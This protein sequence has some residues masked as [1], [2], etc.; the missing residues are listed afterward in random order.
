MQV[1]GFSLDAQRDKLV[2][3]AEY[4]DF[5]IVR[6]YCDAGKS[7]KS[8]TGR[9]QFM[10]MM[11]DVET[12]RD[13]EVSFVLVFKL[14][15]FGR[16]AADV[17]NSL[18]TL[19]D[20]GV[21]LICVE[22]G[23]DSSKDS[24]KLTITVLSAVA[25]IE[26]EN[27]LIQT[28]EGRKQKAREGKWNGG[29]PPYGYDLDNKNSCL[30]INTEEAE[31]VRLIFDKYIH[32]DMG[33]D[34]IA[35]YLN[36]H[37][38]KKNKHFPR[39]LDYFRTSTIKQILVNPV[40]NGKMAYGRHTMEKVKGTRDKYRRVDCDDY[41]V[42]DGMHEAIIDDD[43]WKSARVKNAAVG[44]KWEK[45]YSLEHEHLL[46]GIIKCPVCGT[47]MTGSVSRRIN[48]ETGDYRDDFYYRCHSR[49]KYDGEHF[50]NFRKTF[51]QKKV[52]SEMKNL[53][54]LFTW[55]KTSKDYISELLKDRVDIERLEK[56][57]EQLAAQLK[58]VVGA[59]NKLTEMQDNLTVN[60]RHYNRKYADMSNRLDDLY[61]KID[62]IE[63]SINNIDITLEEATAQKVSAKEIYK[64]LANFD[65]IYDRMEDVEKK[66]FFRTLLE[67]VEVHDDREKQSDGIIK[68]VVFKF[69]VFINGQMADTVMLTKNFTV[70]TVVKLV[71]RNKTRG[72]VSW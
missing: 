61:D 66:K 2:K 8:V 3:Y 17:L 5:E 70:E 13:P 49:K 52:E 67:S 12:E 72:G 62:D 25:E 45:R 34:S 46:S 9:P 44:H 29:R 69:P 20:Y 22:D 54:S 68:K 56:E 33:A 10:Q 21:N 48:K 38:Y 55:D 59:K 14:S 58:Q 50:C 4:K 41:M 60:D 63:Q 57:K 26:R 23:I 11:G 16:N 65:K 43:V 24:G 71:N 32:T 19:Q 28:M 7:G 35:N 18:Q 42:V 27:I 1:E 6:E 39:D 31:V 40:Y 51:N 15:R 53:I 37:G 30:V 64:I 47:G 36:E